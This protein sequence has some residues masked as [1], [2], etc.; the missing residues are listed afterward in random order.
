MDSQRL[1]VGGRWGPE[2]T[3]ATSRLFF[4]R[5]STMPLKAKLRE[6]SCLCF[7]PVSHNIRGHWSSATAAQKYLIGARMWQQGRASTRKVKGAREKTFKESSGDT[8]ISLCPIPPLTGPQ[9]HIQLRCLLVRL[10]PHSS[11]W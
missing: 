10:G 6:W 2:V 8:P 7:N 5:Q 3:G 11:S 1:G 4:E 9:P